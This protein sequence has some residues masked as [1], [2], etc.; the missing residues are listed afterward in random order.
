MR[1][2]SVD[3]AMAV[4]ESRGARERISLAL[5]GEAAVG[6]W[7]LAHQGTA[8]RTMTPDEAADTAAALAALEAVLAGADN[9]DAYFPDLADRAPQLPPHLKSGTDHV[10]WPDRMSGQANKRGLSPIP[11]GADA[12]SFPLIAQLFAKH[13]F[14]ELRAENF[15]SFTARAGHALLL[16][17]EDPVRVKE[18]LDLAVIVPEIVRAFPGRFA[19]GALLPEAAREFQPRYGFR[20]WPA[21]VVL[22]DGQYVGAVDG[23]R[24]WAEYV[25]E[26]ARLLAAAPARPPTVGIAVAGAGGTAGAC[27][28]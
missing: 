11:A 5:V 25:E 18:T 9:V 8:V 17:L 21:V 6:T 24:D 26:V 3:G 16:F 10:Y 27:S 20:R 12:R 2:A 22:K 23:L 19:V 28:H 4:C 7:I 13:G 1:I 14:T 15:D